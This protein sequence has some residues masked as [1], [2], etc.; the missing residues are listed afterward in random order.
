MSTAKRGGFLA[1]LFV[2]G[3]L[4][5]SCQTEPAGPEVGS[6]EWYWSAAKLNYSLGD[7]QKAQ[8]HLGNLLANHPGWEEKALPWRIAILAGLTRGYLELADTYASCA[9]VNAR[10]APNLTNPIQQY[11]RDARRHAIELTEAIN[12]LRKRLET[13]EK[14]TFAFDFP[15]GRPVESSLMENISEGMPPRPDQMPECEKEA[16]QRGVLLQVTAMAGA[17]ED[18]PKARAMFQSGPVEVTRNEMLWVM[19]HTL[20]DLATVFDP[21]HA[22]E[23]D[24]QAFVLDLALQTLEPA[25]TCEDEAVRKRTEELRKEVEKARKSMS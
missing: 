20:L 11:R 17:D 7:Y 5:V 14:V 8:E 4:A 3:L 12:I 16:L 2:A 23:T 13:Q 21:R 9:D 18:T 10:A 15:A 19:G 6:A 25:L 1:A 24:K 22:N